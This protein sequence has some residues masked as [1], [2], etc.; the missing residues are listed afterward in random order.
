ML[1]N[2]IIYIMSTAKYH[3]IKIFN[4]NSAFPELAYFQ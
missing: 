1:C 2:T 3:K 4:L